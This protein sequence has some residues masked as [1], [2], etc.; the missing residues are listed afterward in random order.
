ML[1][2]VAAA[3][4]AMPRPV[5]AQEAAWQKKVASPQ[6][7]E[8]ARAIAMDSSGNVYVAGSTGSSLVTGVANAGLADIWVRKF[9]SGGGVAWTQ[10]VGTS[11]NDLPTGIA[12]DG[13]GSVYVAASTNPSVQ[14][15]FGQDDTLIARLDAANGAIEKTITWG[16]PGD[17]E[18]PSG[19][20]ADS[21]G[22]YV[23]GTGPGSAGAWDAYLVAYALDLGPARWTR[24]IGTTGYDHGRGIAVADGAVWITG[25]ADLSLPGGSSAGKD[26]IFAA[27]YTTTGVQSWLTQTG[28]A[29]D[30]DAGG[31]TVTATAV[32]V[33]GEINTT[34][35]GVSS[36]KAVDAAVWRLSKAGAV[37]WLKRFTAPSNLGPTTTRI[38]G[39]A[40]AGSKVYLT[41]ATNGHF[42]GYP[43]A[44]GP[45]DE[46]VRAIDANGA[47]LWTQQR[48]G[49]GSD[50]GLGAAARGTAV[51]IAGYEQTTTPSYANRG[52]VT[53]IK[54]DPAAA[55]IRLTSPG[56]S[57]W[58]GR[59]ATLSAAVASGLSV[60]RV[61]FRV[62]GA[63]VGSDTAPPFSVTWTSTGTAATVTATLIETSGRTTTTMARSVRVDRTNPTQPDAFELTSAQL[64]IDGSY[65][66]LDFSGATDTGAGI[67]RLQLQ[68]STGAGYKD[69]PPDFDP[70]RGQRQYHLAGNGSVTLRARAVDEAGNLGP[71]RA[72]GEW[73]VS[74]YADAAA[75]YEDSWTI[76]SDPGFWGGNAHQPDEGYKASFSFTGRIVAI[77]TKLGPFYGRINAVID[78]GDDH[79]IDT[80]A[81]VEQFKS[82]VQI[83]TTDGPHAMAME[84]EGTDVFIDGFLVLEYRAP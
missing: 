50:E 68:A 79:W 38:R 32:Y 67:T 16:T 42:P 47:E 36:P 82:P 26:D 77:V 28:T 39:V 21:T 35:P 46:F 81:G 13:A 23:V 34:I 54:E 41:G 65:L 45:R 43:E 27:K 49:N 69:V 59:T 51:A 57:A 7:V 56:A 80:N 55:R 10:Q 15:G 73:I 53:L 17:W 25:D 1:M 78:G 48:G 60:K 20:V 19:I 12:V 9:T 11:K 2:A 64:G 3:P 62:N 63:L 33:G 71:W 61:E 31:I 58:V 76:A 74:K 70:Q 84:T 14:L 22:V 44:G 66:S 75:S 30:D 29:D 40:S 5:A 52:V 37:T 83:D 24:Y 18:T 4:V 6:A 72:G 8:T